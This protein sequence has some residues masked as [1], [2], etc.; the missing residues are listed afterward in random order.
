MLRGLLLSVKEL[1]RPP[2]WGGPAPP[3]VIFETIL[4]KV[5][6]SFSVTDV[7]VFIFTAFI[8]LY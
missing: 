2:G 8:L 3:P 5:L 1:F 7:K 4:L 6:L